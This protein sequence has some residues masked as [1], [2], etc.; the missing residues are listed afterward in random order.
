MHQRGERAQTM[1]YT[2]HVVLELVAVQMIRPP[3]NVTILSNPLI[4][5]AVALPFL[6]ICSLSI[7]LF[8]SALLK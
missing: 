1:S 7:R 6:S 3:Y 2:T 8:C 5:A 4:N